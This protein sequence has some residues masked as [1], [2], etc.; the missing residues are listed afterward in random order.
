MTTTIITFEQGT[1]FNPRIIR[2]TTSAT[3]AQVTTVGFLNG[4]IGQGFIFYPTDQFLI[5]YNTDSTPVV[6][7]FVVS[8]VNGVYTLALMPGG[9]VLPVV[10]GDFAN[11]SGTSGLITDLGLSPTNA[12]KTKVVMANSAVTIG[13]L[14]SY[15][16]TAGTITDSGVTASGLQI[17]SAS[18]TLNQAAVQGM[19]A[20]P[21]QIVAAPAAGH[22]LV[23]VQATIY[24]NFQTAAFTGGGIAILQYDSTVHGA[25]TNALAATIPTAEITAAASQIYNLGGNTANALTAIT[26]KGLYL[27]NA[28]GAFTA[29]NAA[30]TVVVTVSYYLITATV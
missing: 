10:N 25:G 2:I 28:T 20:A 5:A 16:D 7:D 21:F 23:P 22:V 1:G 9:V 24:T 15:S 26:A 12:S 8:I 6:A 13:N 29:G 4:P 18:V 14:A 11:F 17:L 3:Y 30:S 27:S 19:Y